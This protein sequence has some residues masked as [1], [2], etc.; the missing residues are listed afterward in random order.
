MSDP[1]S[2]A[3]LLRVP[4]VE[5]VY[6]HDEGGAEGV[7]AEGEDVGVVGGEERV[8]GVSASL[9][10]VRELGPNIVSAVLSV[11]SSLTAEYCLPGDYEVP[12]GVAGAGA[13]DL[14]V[15]VQR[16]DGHVAPVVA[17]RAQRT[18]GLFFTTADRG[19]PVMLPSQSRMMPRRS[20]SPLHGTEKRGR[21]WQAGLSTVVIKSVLPLQSFPPPRPGRGMSYL[22]TR[23]GSPCTRRP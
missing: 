4:G 3:D 16:T 23:W 10:L 11:I 2:H 19:R 8:P 9:R 5:A 14:A 12:V 6:D 22:G 7:V 18:G 13:G 21:P 17:A 20:G 1:P 15:A